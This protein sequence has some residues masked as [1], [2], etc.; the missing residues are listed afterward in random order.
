VSGWGK[1]L[2]YF[3]RNDRFLADFVDKAEWI[4]WVM[5]NPPV[6]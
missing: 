2:T 5:P 4:S 1:K 6:Q 3:E